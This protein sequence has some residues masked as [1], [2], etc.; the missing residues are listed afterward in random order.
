M[1]KRLH[2]V[3]ALLACLGTVPLAH[4]GEDSCL[5]DQIAFEKLTPGGALI[6]A[7]GGPVQVRTM[8]FPGNN[9]CPVITT[10]EVPDGFFDDSRSKVLWT[11]P[12]GELFGNLVEY[13][14][15]PNP[16]GSVRVARWKR[17]FRDH[18]DRGEETLEFR[19]AANPNAPPPI[20][21]DEGM[22]GADRTCSNVKMT[23]IKS[24]TDFKKD[25]FAWSPNRQYKLI[26]QWDGNLVLYEGASEWLWDI[27]KDTKKS[28]QGG[29]M[30]MQTD[31]NLVSYDP[32]NRPLWSSKTQGKPGAF[33]A[34]QDDGNVVIYAKDSCKA[35]WARR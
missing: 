11:S 21:N 27:Q 16:T 19:Q 8:R 14:V 23:T 31:G 34:V 7:E 33:L 1:I 35:L 13:R 26:W 12:P 28:N 2:F 22:L 6:P 3:V 20:S 32:S 24:G 5:M 30:V 29:R 15:T 18:P 4:A 17:H 9:S 10:R 25:S